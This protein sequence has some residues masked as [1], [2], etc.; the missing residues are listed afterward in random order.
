LGLDAFTQNAPSQY[1]AANKRHLQRVIEIMVER[2]ASP[3]T[4]D[5]AASQG[6]KSLGNIVM[7]RT[8][9]LA[10]IL[11]QKLAKLFS[12][13]SRNRLH[14]RR[15][16]KGVLKQ[17]ATDRNVVE[18]RLYKLWFAETLSQKALTVNAPGRPRTSVTS[19]SR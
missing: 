9:S 11:G 10:E 5:C 1:V 12:R 18:G 19:P 17:C 8:K 13:K 16:F 7:S 4:F 2:I 14:G 6:S 15:P 3:E